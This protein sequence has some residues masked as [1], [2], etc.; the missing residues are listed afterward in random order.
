MDRLQER[1]AHGDDFAWIAIEAAG[2]SLFHNSNIDDFDP[3]PE[4]VN[5]YP[6]P[7]GK[8]N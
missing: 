5:P 1:A 2:G 4:G 6:V 8:T 7:V 3:V